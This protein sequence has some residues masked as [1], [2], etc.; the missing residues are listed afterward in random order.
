MG[1]SIREEK[2]PPQKPYMRLCLKLTGPKVIPSQALVQS[3][4]G[5][6]HICGMNIT[7]FLNIS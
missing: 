4:M 7:K 6:N 5:D 2:L 3:H 1:I